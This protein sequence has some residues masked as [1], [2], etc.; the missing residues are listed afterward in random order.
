MSVLGPQVQGMTGWREEGSH[1]LFILMVGLCKS[2]FAN[3]LLQFAQFC[4][5]LWG[6]GKGGDSDCLLGHSLQCLSLQ[7]AS[8]T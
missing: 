1:L 4:S 8:E 6:K 5:C 2:I 3:V 7:S